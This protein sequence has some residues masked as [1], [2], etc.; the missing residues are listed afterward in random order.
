MSNRRNLLFDPP[1]H[2]NWLLLKDKNL[3]VAFSG[4]KDSL[5]LLHYLKINER[6]LN[7]RIHAIHINHSLRGEESDR[8]EAFCRRY[9]EEHKIVFK[10]RSINVQE[11]SLVKERGMEYA[12]RKLRYNVLMGERESA[13]YDYILTAHTLDDR[14]ETFFTD[15]ITGA[16]IFTLG[17]VE[18]VNGGILRPFL[19][20]TSKMIEEFLEVH[21]LTPVYDSSNNDARYVRNM[22]RSYAPFLST[23][24]SAVLRVQEESARLGS[25][26]AQRTEGAVVKYGDD[27]VEIDRGVLEEMSETEQGYI[28]GKWVSRLCRGGKVHSDM[29]I[30]SLE[31]KDSLRFSLPMGFA[32]EISFKSI[33]IFPAVWFSPF[34]YIKPPGKLTLEIPDRNLLI[35]FPESLKDR[36]LLIRNREVGDKFHGK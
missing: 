28:I 36:E 20:V 35:V 22:V 7:A 3:A 24:K 10:S 1:L 27:F 11:S 9:C 17:G 8:D 30:K 18:A 26:L 15:L 19:S 34:H 23:M 5:A 6:T 16:S 25:W 2:G 33:H 32:A 12:A 14:I 31:H 21:K 29:I 4:G 13:G